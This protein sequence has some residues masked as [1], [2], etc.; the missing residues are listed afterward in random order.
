MEVESWFYFTL[1]KGS[2]TY[3]MMT[4]A[5]SWCVTTWHSLVEMTSL[6]SSRHAYGNIIC[7]NYNFCDV[8]VLFSLDN[9][10]VYVWPISTYWLKQYPRL[11][12]WHH[13][14]IS[15]L[16]LFFRNSYVLSPHVWCIYCYL[17]ASQ[18]LLSCLLLSDFLVLMTCHYACLCDDISLQFFTGTS[19]GV[20]VNL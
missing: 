12:W 2:F 1:V 6:S 7:I 10:D 16:M 11:R 4:S 3:Y 19:S 9:F 8:F 13:C 18:I 17:V 20:R 15:W 14:C 5:P